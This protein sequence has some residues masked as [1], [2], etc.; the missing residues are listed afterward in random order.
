MVRTLVP[1]SI[2]SAEQVRSNSGNPRRV[3]VG[4]WAEAWARSRERPSSERVRTPTVATTGILEIIRTFGQTNDNIGANLIDASK[5]T[6][7]FRLISNMARGLTAAVGLLAALGWLVRLRRGYLDVPM[8][9]LWLAPIGLQSA[10]EMQIAT[11][12]MRPLTDIVR[13]A[14]LAAVTAILHSA[15]ER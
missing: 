7:G 11:E 10:S 1:P 6:P 5:F 2:A 9:L 14:R 13:S 4:V 12:A 8:T 3:T 15:W